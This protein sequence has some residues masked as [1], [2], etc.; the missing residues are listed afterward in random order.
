VIGKK[1]FFYVFF[2]EIVFIL[3]WFAQ[4]KPVICCGHFRTQ[5]YNKIFY[6]LKVDD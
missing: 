1:S 2:L 5:L 6:K 3:L 4:L